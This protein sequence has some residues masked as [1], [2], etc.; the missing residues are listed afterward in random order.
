MDTLQRE[1]D[2]AEYSKEGMVYLWDLQERVSK[3]PNKCRSCNT[4][5]RPYCGVCR[6]EDL[7]RASL[8][9]GG[10]FTGFMFGVP[11]TKI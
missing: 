8:V 6:L 11:Q 10:E 4:M 3:I 5:C 1:E 7:Y 9:Q 2:Q